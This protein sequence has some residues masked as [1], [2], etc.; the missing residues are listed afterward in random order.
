MIEK[1]LKELT[2]LGLV[3]GGYDAISLRILSDNKIKSNLCELLETVKLFK[4]GSIRI[5]FTKIQTKNIENILKFKEMY[6]DLM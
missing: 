3:W 1:K 4:D 6:G 2:I 5:S